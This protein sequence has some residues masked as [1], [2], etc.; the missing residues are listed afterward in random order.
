M[1]NEIGLRLKGELVCRG[2]GNILTI[3]GKF[4]FIYYCNNNLCKFYKTFLTRR[5]IK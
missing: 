1:V 2:C 3:H 4:G 5:M